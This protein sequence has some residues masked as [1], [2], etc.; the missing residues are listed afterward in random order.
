MLF[1]PNKTLITFAFNFQNPIGLLSYAFFHISPSHLF[2]NLILLLAVGFIAEKKLSSR[3]FAFVF[4]TAAVASAL[5]YGLLFPEN[6]LVGA[7]A[8]ISAFLAIAFI[9]DFKKTIFLVV[10]ASMLTILISPLLLSYTEIKVNE[11]NQRSELLEKQL[12]ETN[13]AIEK[14]LQENDSEQ[15]QTLSLIKQTKINEF[16][17]TLIA[18]NIL[19]EGVEREESSQTS[20][21]VH[22]TGAF[23]GLAYLWLFKRDV[24]WEMPYQIIP[25]KYLHKNL[26]KN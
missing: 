8:A 12:N 14:A 24:L 26:K 2:G 3:E 20:P 5:V 1:I 23:V 9:I 7:S 25:Q 10:I 21:L 22:L 4:M 18:K 15:V 11:L 19:T 16:N 17:N 13:K 6:Y